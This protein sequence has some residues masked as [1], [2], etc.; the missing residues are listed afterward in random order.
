MV[1]DTLKG[2]QEFVGTE[3]TDQPDLLQPA[4]Y[5]HRG[6]DPEGTEYAPARLFVLVPEATARQG[7]SRGASGILFGISYSQNAN[8]GTKITLFI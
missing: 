4:L 5:I 1:A 7:A 3:A 8:I 6:G 2:V